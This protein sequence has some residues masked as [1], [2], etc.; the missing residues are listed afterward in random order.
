MYWPKF[1][2]S[3]TQ[4]VTRSGGGSPSEPTGEPWWASDLAALVRAA[5]DPLE[6]KEGRRI[7]TEQNKKQQTSKANQHINK[8]T[9]KTH[10]KQKTK[11][12]Q[13]GDGEDPR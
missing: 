12:D 6:E 8:Q 5:I 7:C 9:K 4:A 1:R 11:P 13:Q 3:D 2:V 10:T